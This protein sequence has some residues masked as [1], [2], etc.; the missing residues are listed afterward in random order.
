VEPAPHEPAGASVPIDLSAVPRA[1][2]PRASRA[3]QRPPEPEEKAERASGDW[4][5]TAGR[6]CT[7][8]GAAMLVAGAVVGLTGKRLGDTLS[9]RYAMGALRPGDAKLYDRVD[10]YETIA[11]ALFVAG[12]VTAAAGI[13]FF[14][15]TPTPGGATV[16]VAVNF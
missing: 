16:A 9:D 6:W 8:G 2:T 3:A 14:I 5:R 11:N 1:E 7:G 10:R 12:G 4:R 15:V 13:G